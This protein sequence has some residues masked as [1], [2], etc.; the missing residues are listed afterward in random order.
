MIAEKVLMFRSTDG[1]LHE[2]ESDCLERN[3]LLNSRPKIMALIESH[4]DIDL[5]NNPEKLMTAEEVCNW[6][7]KC[8][9]E[10]VAILS[11][12][13]TPLEEPRR[14]RTKADMALEKAA[15]AVI[16]AQKGSKAPE[17]AKP[18][19]PVAPVVAGHDVNSE[20]TPAVTAK[21]VV[22]KSISALDDEFVGADDEA[23][24][25]LESAGK[26]VSVDQW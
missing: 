13:V 22:E 17:A 24:D 16:Q 9:S 26:G 20:S 1:A 7:M 14:R 18:V 11:P 3:F 6:L 23:D 10:I 8:N 19:A 12:L 2:K 5:N 25:G 15:Q 4:G 21:A